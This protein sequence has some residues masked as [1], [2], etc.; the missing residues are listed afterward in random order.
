MSDVAIG[1]DG[2]PPGH[3]D[4]PLIGALK[5]WFA[6]MR[7]EARRD[8]EANRAMLRQALAARQPA[9]APVKANGTIDANG[10]LVLDLGGPQQGRRWAVRMVTFSDAGSF[11]ATMGT[12]NVAVAIGQKTG[13]IITP[14]SVRWPFTVTPNS[15]SFGSDEVW[16]TPSDNVLLAVTSGTV[17]QNVQC[18]AWI[19]DFDPAHVRTT[20][21]V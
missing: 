9:Y 12:A 15:A 19:Q 16:V 10:R 6:V 18:T 21:E 2:R 20:A 5:H 17:G 13:N 3:E 4:G 14:D 1:D 7:D 8:R 11:W